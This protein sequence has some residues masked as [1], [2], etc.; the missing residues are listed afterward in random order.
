[1][2][3][4]A[5]FFLVSL[6]FNACVFVSLFFLCIS[7]LMNLVDFKQVLAGKLVCL[8]YLSSG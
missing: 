1:M 3:N 2:Q 5:F 7:M 4:I 8:A 6:F